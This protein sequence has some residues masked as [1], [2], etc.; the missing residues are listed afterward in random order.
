VK[1]TLEEIEGR[2]RDIC[3][4]AGMDPDFMSY[5]GQDDIGYAIREPNWL[6]CWEEAKEELE[7]ERHAG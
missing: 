5:E 7:E 3:V 2:A 4:R 1:P 6:L